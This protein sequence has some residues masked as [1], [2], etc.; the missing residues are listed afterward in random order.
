MNLLTDLSTLS[1][2]KEYN[3]VKLQSLIIDIISHTVVEGLK[4]KDKVIEIDIGI[5]T[6][7][8]INNE[9]T[10]QYKFIPNAKLERTIIKAY[11]GEDIL[12]N[13]LEEEI[14]NRILKSYEEL[15]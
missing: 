8:I 13:K 2:I 9:G 14:T 5:G 1:G 12:L 7:Y 4:N 11:N 10:I 15:Y 6:L 3:L